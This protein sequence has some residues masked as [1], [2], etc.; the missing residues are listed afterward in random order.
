M[1]SKLEMPR[2]LS[3]YLTKTNKRMWHS[4]KIIYNFINSL[5]VWCMTVTT[6][7]DFPITVYNNAIIVFT[8]LWNLLYCTINKL[9][10]SSKLCIY[11]VKLST[12]VIIYLL[13]LL[14]SSDKSVVPCL[15]KKLIYIYSLTQLKG[16]IIFSKCSI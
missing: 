13:L 7:V 8:S 1:Y 14:C 11:I 12:V 2:L 5:C 15:N 16:I 10:H 9:Y 4:L 6:H 3:F